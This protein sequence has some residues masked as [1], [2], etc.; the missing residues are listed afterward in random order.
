MYFRTTVIFVSFL[1]VFIIS[2]NQSSEFNTTE[3][4]DQISES[5]KTT[6]TPPPVVKTG[7]LRYGE[8]LSSI[9]HKHNI[10]SKSVVNI[11]SQFREVYDVRRMRAHDEYTVATD[12]SGTFQ[13]FSYK[14]S[15]EREYIVELNEAG[16]LTARANEINLV[17]K[18]RNLQGN[19]KTTLYD[20]ILESGETPELLVAIS[21]I[22]QW[23]VDFF[24]DPR[25]DDSFK[26][27]FEAFYL[28]E[29]SSESASAGEKFVR[30]GKVLAA[31]YVLQ[32]EELTAI[33]FDNSPKDDG[34]YTPEGESF[35]KTFLKS[36]LNYRRISSYFS[37]ARKHPILKIVRPHYGVD[38]A[39]PT[40]TPV[41]AAADGVIIKKGYDK[42]IGRF[43]K[44]RHKNPRFVTLYG[45]LSR[46]ATGMAEGISVKQKDVIGY[47]GSTGLAT[48]PHLHY[49]FYENGRPIDPL[50]IKNTSGDPISSENL[51]KFENVLSDML[52]R[53]EDLDG[54]HIPL[55]QNQAQY[56]HFNRYCISER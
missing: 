46:F 43:I 8:T 39:A 9:L 47:V 31:Q 49:T 1:F 37:Y 35:Q 33:Y 54:L 11:I 36:P 7:K 23:D 2:C 42:G 34:Y 38:F 6:V 41:S 30:Y 27:V 48:G 53:L 26:I 13:K 29:D 51:Q 17:R 28:P 40:G 5:A 22:F 21:D 15:L 56:I 50:K 14:P 10:D 55:V 25:V 44:I 16:E 24:I 20:A 32:G 19:I 45:H 18:I 12:S 52:A 3:T 4:V